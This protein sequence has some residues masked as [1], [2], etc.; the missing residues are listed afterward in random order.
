MTSP[1]PMPA[2]L[3]E[4]IDD[5]AG[6]VGQE[7]LQLLL[8][9][10]ENLPALPERYADHPELLE[11]VPECQSPVFLITEVD[12][13]VQPPVARL[14]FTAP[15]EAPTTRGFAGILREGLDG[16][17]VDEVLS[18]PAD[19]AMQL[20]LAD[21]VSP[22]RLRGLSAMLARVKRQLAE[23]TRSDT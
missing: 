19:F 22:L 4:I 14:F 13:D 9:F 21:V 18:T 8:E 11:P 15:P 17:P 16:L 20:P 3:S 6:L 12:R 10:A 1:A 2:A 5:F 23:A 7:K